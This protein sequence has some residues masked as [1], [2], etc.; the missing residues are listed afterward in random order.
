MDTHDAMSKLNPHEAT[1]ASTD[2]QQP[3]RE[4]RH[5]SGDATVSPTGHAP[6]DGANQESDVAVQ[7]QPV[8]GELQQH[9]DQLKTAA[10]EPSKQPELLQQDASNW[11][12]S[13]NHLVAKVPQLTEANPENDK[14]EVSANHGA[15]SFHAEADVPANNTVNQEAKANEI[16]PVS[17]DTSKTVPP[18]ATPE[19]LRG[20]PYRLS[21]SLVATDH[22]HEGTELDAKT[23]EVS[24]VQQHEATEQPMPTMDAQEVA[25]YSQDY[26][27]GSSVEEVLSDTESLLGDTHDR[28]HSK[29]NGRESSGDEPSCD[30]HDCGD[31]EEDDGDVEW[32]DEYLRNLAT[33]IRAG[34]NARSGLARRQGHVPGGVGYIMPH[35]DPRQMQLNGQHGFP[36][37]ANADYGQQQPS[38]A[39]NARAVPGMQ[40]PRSF[41]QHDMQ[42]HPGFQQMGYQAHQGANNFL[43]GSSPMSPFFQGVAQNH[44]PHAAHR[45]HMMGFQN[46]PYTMQPHGQYSPMTA[47]DQFPGSPYAMQ[48]RPSA[49]ALS[50]QRPPTSAPVASRPDTRQQGPQRSA[51]VEEFDSSEDDEP[52]HKRVAHHS[53]AAGESAITVKGKRMDQGKESE[54]EFVASKPKLGF[55]A[56]KEKKSAPKQ[57]PV[58]STTKTVGPAIKGPPSSAGSIDWTLPRF[59]AQFEPGATKNDPTVAKVSIPGIVREEIFLSPDHAEQ[60]THLLLHIFLP[61][62]R[63]LETPDTN[64]AVAILNFH[65][66]AVMVIEAFVQFEIGDEYGLG[67]GHW[68]NDHDEDGVAEYQRVRDAKDADPDDIFF[69]VIDRWRAGLESNKQ[70]SKLIRGTQEFCDI[71]LDIIYYIR[72][73]GLLEERQRAVR[74]D[75]GVKRGAKKLEEQEQSEDEDTPMKGTKRGAGKIHEP[76]VT[77]KAKVQPKAKTPAK[78]RKSR[79]KV[80]A[81]TVIRKAR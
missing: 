79:A 72:E 15:S 30:E 40:D 74:S 81:V 17:T 54:V 31:V 80:A 34:V 12:N 56:T 13:Q 20:N 53:S 3:M 28:L 44:P 10:E 8:K 51:A 59:E 73:H 24:K 65:T 50:N 2:S 75:K 58:P 38:Q 39:F 64:P 52:L 23:D 68:H 43:Q 21:G 41:Q 57:G 9:I 6:Q 16:E 32:D 62:Q 49:P 47:Y 78:P 60:E 1:A 69:A 14:V 45:Q 27:G 4:E 66:V 46:P 67:R 76:K 70:P 7:Q 55:K 22:G 33:E 37:F 11:P 5:N 42:Q 48:A 19:S 61:N 71:A 77:K 63:R 29:D 26:E 36:G 25:E 18:S 35:Q